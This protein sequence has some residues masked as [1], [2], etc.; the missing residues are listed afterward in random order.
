MQE[1]KGLAMLILCPQKKIT[2]DV[3]LLK[4]R[5]HL[6]DNVCQPGDGHADVGD[7]GAVARPSALAGV[8]QLVPC[9]PQLRSFLH[10]AGVLKAAAAVLLDDLPRGA[11]H[12]ANVRLVAGDLEE[13]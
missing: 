1:K 5:L 8:V 11:H 12:R 9:L 2:I 7:D 3:V 13:E 6:Q 4:V 10:L